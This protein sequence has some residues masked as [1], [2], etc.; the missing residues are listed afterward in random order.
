M[1][2]ISLIVGC[3]TREGAVKTYIQGVTV[4]AVGG[5]LAALALDMGVIE[6]AAIGTALGLLFSHNI[7]ENL[8]QHISAKNELN[9][10]IVHLREENHKI[11]AFNRHLRGEAAKL[12]REIVKYDRGIRELNQVIQANLHELN[13]VVNKEIPKLLAEV[14]DGQEQIQRELKRAESV[15][16]DQHTRHLINLQDSLTNTELELDKIRSL[17]YE[18]AERVSHA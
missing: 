12:E 1:I 9:A 6:G 17:A 18:Y 2:L 10:Q 4:G 3:S 13:R 7:N 5:S 11:L 16:A 15:G 8:D 14:S